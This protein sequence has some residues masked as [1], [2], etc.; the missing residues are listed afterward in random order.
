MG[1]LFDLSFTKFVTPTIAKI[2]Y[3]VGAVLIA[4]SYIVFVVVAFDTSTA[5]GIFVLLIGGPIAALFYLSILRVALES[6]MAMIL[7]A[8]NTAELVRIGGGTPPAGPRFHPDAPSGPPPG[9]YPPP[10]AP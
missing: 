2:V 9:D 5:A 1:A 7:T 8:Q 4:L 10:S 6:L 3:I